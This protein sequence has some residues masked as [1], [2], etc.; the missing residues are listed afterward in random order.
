MKNKNIIIIV[1]LLIVV[2]IGYWIYSYQ[3]TPGEYDE[4]AKCLTENEVVMY[5]TDWCEYC[6]KQKS[7]FGKSFKYVNYVNCDLNKKEC[8]S[9]SVEGYPTWKINNKTY[10]GV[11]PLEQLSV[12]SGCDF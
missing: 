7:T 5:G 12:L 6:Q 4:F 9:N 10:P 8:L 1:S 3:T 2:G 11:K